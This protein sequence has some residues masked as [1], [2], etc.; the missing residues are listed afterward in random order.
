MMRTAIA[1]SLMLAV[2]AAPAAAAETWK[3]F[4]SAD[5]YQSAIAVESIKATGTQRSFRLK[6]GKVGETHYAIANALL[7]CQ[8][9]T[10]TMGNADLFDKGVQTGTKL[11][12]P[13]K[14]FTEPLGDEPSGQ[15]ILAFVC[16]G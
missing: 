10:L 14:P 12:D 9:K 15:E 7:D 2:A 6:V 3:E 13:A 8:A 1:L 11:A 16:M 4:T 5:G